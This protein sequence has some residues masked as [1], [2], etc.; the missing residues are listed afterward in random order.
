MILTYLMNC[1]RTSDNRE[2]IS[3]LSC[4]W[5]TLSTLFIS[6]NVQYTPSSSVFFVLNFFTWRLGK[7]R[8]GSSILLIQCYFPI[9]F[10]KFCFQR[11]SNEHNLLNLRLDINCQ[12]RMD[13]SKYNV[14]FISSIF[15][16]IVFKYTHIFQIVDKTV[17][18]YTTT[19]FRCTPLLYWLLSK[20]LI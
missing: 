18:V 5:W 10:F 14:A 3:Q 12:K 11:K 17:V 9:Y 15:N 13:F 7:D 20:Y 1:V 4:Q 16:S 8:N 19:K 2:N 6:R